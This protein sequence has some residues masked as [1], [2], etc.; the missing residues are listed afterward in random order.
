MLSSILDINI[1]SNRTDIRR[2]II[3]ENKGV[4]ATINANILQHAFNNESYRILLQNNTINICDGS[5]VAL[6]FNVIMKVKI[7]P[8]AGPDFFI[9]YIKESKYKHAFIG[10]TEKILEGLRANLSKYDGDIENSLFLPLPYK[11]V[12]DFDYMEISK[13]INAVKPDFIWVSLGAPKQEEFSS[14]LFRYINSGFIVPVGAAFDF[15]SYNGASNRCPLFLRRLKLEWLFRLWVQPKR[16]S[17]RLM[18]EL[19]FIPIIF[20]REVFNK[21]K[22]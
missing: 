3:R 4:I 8:Y 7:V 5:M 6:I 11:S 13:K 15:Y 10:T 20:W 17:K 1:T 16:T 19:V 22:K 21:I 2:I 14:E 18:L 9:D 12:E